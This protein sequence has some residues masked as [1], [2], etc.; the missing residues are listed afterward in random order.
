M[1]SFKLQTQISIIWAY[2]ALHNYIKKMDS[3]DL[4]ILERFENL[5]DLE[6]RQHNFNE[7]N[8]NEVDHGEWQEPTQADVRYMEEIRNVIRDQLL[9][10]RHS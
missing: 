2:F 8:V 5:N 1:T 10:E 3:S 6:G 4:N 7:E 9:I